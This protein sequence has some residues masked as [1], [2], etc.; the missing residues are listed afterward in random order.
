[1]QRGG[2]LFPK[3]RSRFCPKPVPGLLH[4]TIPFRCPHTERFVP[5]PL[6]SRRLPDAPSKGMHVL[7]MAALQGGMQVTEAS[8]E[9]S[10]VDGGRGID[11]P[12]TMQASILQGLVI[13]CR[14]QERGTAR[15]EVL[16]ALLGTTERVVQEV[17][18][19]EY[20]LTDIQEYYAN[21]GALTRAAQNARGGV[22][23]HSLLSPPLCFQC[24]ICEGF[25][26][27]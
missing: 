25:S 3:S 9:A 15:P 2:A 7:S 1:M 22:V 6:L 14:G 26:A 5:A 21:T 12:S 20:G 19:V 23:S 27:P 8:V 24:F 17:D 16:Q 4:V 11:S 10:A 13:G 18:S